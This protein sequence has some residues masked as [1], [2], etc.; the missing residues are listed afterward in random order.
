MIIYQV[1]A[2]I[3]GMTVEKIHQELSI[4]DDI[5]AIMGGGLT[6]AEVMADSMVIKLFLRARS[7]QDINDILEACD[8]VARWIKPSSLDTASE[9]LECPPDPTEDLAFQTLSSLR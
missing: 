7:I 6:A 4:V 5:L 2:E 8:F 1:E 9:A 3:S